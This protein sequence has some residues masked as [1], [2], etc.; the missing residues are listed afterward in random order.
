MSQ[1]ALKEL[2]TKMADDELILGHR[3]SEW[4]GLG[5][6]LEEDI[7]FSS[8]AQDKI[9]H[10]VAL[11]TILHEELGE[12]VA[13]KLAYHRTDK[14]F[15]CAHLVEL[16]IGEYDF[17][18]VRHFFFDHAEYNRYHLLEK[19]SF[20]RL[21]NLAKKIRGELKYHVLHADTWLKKLGHGND[22]S[23]AR[24]QTSINET[25]PFALGIFEKSEFEK[26]LIKDGV[27][28]GE[29]ALQRL[30]LDSITPIFKEA[31]LKLPD[32]NKTEPVYGGRKGFH[33]V[34]LKPLLDEM[35]E[36]YRLEPDAEW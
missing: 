4:T 22:E 18:L 2:L 19:S 20:E 14:Q 31:N 36:V 35:T 33:T 29:E 7:A 30:W 5:P 8:M 3:N 10:S 21:A 13:D 9:G 23:N 32:I 15:R 16:P 34:H 26:D 11:Y 27:F 6:I 1:A 25:F 12:P 24:L 28:D 17:S